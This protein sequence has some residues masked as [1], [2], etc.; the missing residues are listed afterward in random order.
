MLVCGLAPVPPSFGRQS[1]VAE[2]RFAASDL[3]ECKALTVDA[4]WPWYTQRGA[5]PLI[6]G[7][8][9]LGAPGNVVT[10]VA[11]RDISEW[12]ALRGL[13][14]EVQ[15]AWDERDKLAP[16]QTT[17]LLMVQSDYGAC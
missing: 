2:T 1:V 6:Y 10:Y 13:D 12:H 7:H 9:P 5:R 8:D 3:A 4:I 14:S 15:A 11:F 17:R 16:N